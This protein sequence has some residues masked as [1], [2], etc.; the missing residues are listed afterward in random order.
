MNK[1]LNKC[2]RGFA[3]FA[4]YT[5]FQYWRFTDKDLYKKNKRDYED[6]LVREQITASTIKQFDSLKKRYP[7]GWKPEPGK[8]DLIY[9]GDIPSPR[10]FAKFGPTDND[11]KDTKKDEV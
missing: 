10:K 6:K 2:K 11:R 7:G 1:V 9:I 8:H 5:K 3:K 4:W